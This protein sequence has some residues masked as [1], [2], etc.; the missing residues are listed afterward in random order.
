MALFAAA[1]DAVRCGPRFGSINYGRIYQN[2][3]QAGRIYAG[4]ERH[5]SADNAPHEMGDALL[6][7]ANRSMPSGSR[8]LH[9]GASAQMGAGRLTV[10]QP[11]QTLD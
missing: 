8:L 6:P 7:V 10:I 9:L 11:D 2:Q 3:G 1:W 4:R 5:R